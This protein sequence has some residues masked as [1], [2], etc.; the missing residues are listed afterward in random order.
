MEQD[1]PAIGPYHQ[2]IEKLID[3]GY[4][5]LKFL[6]EKIMHNSSHRD[7]LCTI[8][9]FSDNGK[10]YE[11]RPASASDFQPNAVR[12]ARRLFILEGLSQELVEQIGSALDVEPEFFA[13]QMRGTTWEHHD[14]R[15]NAS[16]LPS[17]RQGVGFWALEYFEIIRLNSVF[18][19]GR[20]RLRPHS[21]TFRRIIIRNPSKDSSGSFSFALIARI[22]SFWKRTYDDGAFDGRKSL[23]I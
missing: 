14:D 13:T 12:H 16:M 6:N 18:P 21:P 10:A 9:N 15:S 3:A 7:A 19:L 22:V 20:T 1:S 2:F 17:V 5:N 11:S 8:V 23:R 4:A